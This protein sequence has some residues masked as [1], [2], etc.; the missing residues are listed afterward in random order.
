MAGYR[1]LRQVERLIKM[2]DANLALRQKVQK[3]KPY[4]IGDSLEQLDRFIQGI[5]SL[6]LHPHSRI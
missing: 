4:R 6:L 1:R 5:R 2:A 3:P